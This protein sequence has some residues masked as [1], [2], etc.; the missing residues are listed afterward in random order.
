MYR[1]ILNWKLLGNL[2]YR[3]DGWIYWAGAGVAWFSGSTTFSLANIHIKI[4]TGNLIVL[5]A[6]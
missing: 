4:L 1:Y 2:V 3:T 6:T 5:S